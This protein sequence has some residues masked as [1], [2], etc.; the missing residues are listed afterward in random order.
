MADGSGGHSQ[1]RTP[2][3]PSC[4]C[5]RFADL[6]QAHPKCVLEPQHVDAP[7]ASIGIGNPL[8]RVPYQVIRSS[9]G[10]PFGPLSAAVRNNRGFVG[11]LSALPRI[12]ASYGNEK[13]RDSSQQD[14]LSHFAW[15]CFRQFIMRVCFSIA[16]IVELRMHNP[17]SLIKTSHWQFRRQPASTK[18]QNDLRRS[19]PQS[20]CS[21][22]NVS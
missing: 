8:C 10:T 3:P 9:T 17:T 1:G 6:P 19:R 16:Q 21:D 14:A 11:I 22:V 5:R 4:R 15:G 12:S 13:A 7:C 2:R 18:A 20:Y